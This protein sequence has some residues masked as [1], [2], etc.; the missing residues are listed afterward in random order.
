MNTIIFD[1]DGTLINSGKVITNSI[2]FVREN[3][4]LEKMAEKEILEY[5]NTP[6]INTAEILYGTKEFTPEQSKLFENYYTQN[7]TKDIELYDG[8]KE[9]LKTLHKENKKLAIATNAFSSFAKE[10]LEYLDIYRYFDVIVGADMVKK[11]KPNPEMILNIMQNLN[12][13]KSHTILIGDSH[14]DR[15]SAKSA[16]IKF[17][18]VNWGFSEHNENVINRAE[19]IL[20][21]L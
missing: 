4:G 3:I 1:M 21:N 8:I 14:K 17:L 7:C 15:L 20:E 2:N 18:L 19:E 5:I 16:E 13:D 10:M 6:H 9:V 12:A 11:P